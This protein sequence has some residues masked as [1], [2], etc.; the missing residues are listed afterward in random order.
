[1]LSITPEKRIRDI[2]E[3]FTHAF[4]FLKVEFLHG[5][6]G[7]SGRKDFIPHDHYL[8]A[9]KHSDLNGQ[10]AHPQIPLTPGLTILEL[11]RHC[12]ELFGVSVQVYRR[13][14]K[15]WLEATMTENLTLQQQNDHG[16]EISM[17]IY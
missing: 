3:E 10:A 16:S 14:R 15:L 13:F 8:K 6:D 11:E 12:E 9:R 2:Q 7:E 17:N 5:T 4:P 1:M